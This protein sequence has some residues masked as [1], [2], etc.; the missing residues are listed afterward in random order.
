MAIVYILAITVVSVVARKSGRT[1]EGFVRGVRTY[2]AAVIGL[3]LASEVIGTSSSV[4]TAQGGFDDGIS[5]A[6]NLVA[7][8]LGFIA[9]AVF[10]ASRFK[11]L[12][13]V[14]ISGALE[15]C[16]GP[17]VRRAASITTTVA[18][19]LVATACY[20]GGGAVLSSL[21]GV[22]S[23][24]AVVIVGILASG[25]VALGGMQSVIYTNLLNV[26][27]KILSVVLVAV[28]AYRSAGGFGGVRL[29]LPPT[30]LD[31][32]GVGWAQIGAWLIAGGG[33]M[34]AT[35]YVVQSMTAVE[36][37]RKARTASLYTSLILIPYG[38]LAALIGVFAAVAHPDVPSIQA[39]PSMI[40]DMNPILAGIAATGLLASVFGQLSALT[41]G[42]ATL[43]FKDFY[44]P[45]F[46]RDSDDAKSVRFIRIATVVCGL[47]PVVLALFAT[48]IL[49]VAFLGK[50]LRALLS[51]FVVLMF[52]RPGFGSR[53]AATWS[54]WIAAAATISWFLIG[55][56]F[57]IDNAYVAIV[58]PLVIM[59]GAHVLR[60][61]TKPRPVLVPEAGAEPVAERST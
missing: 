51:V 11:K 44:L 8:G 17:G 5:A 32:D 54:V 35:Q 34:F 19:M 60:L 41:I 23:T 1:S 59:G 45:Y 22:S 25:Y 58:V 21:L 48:D 13:E 33:A 16:Y 10:L 50:A 9:F 24:W 2:P 26:V 28:A 53:E 30:M 61:G 52:Y 40:V 20:A 4:G 55:E 12:D 6:W 38:L 43:V 27:L 37:A 39:L 18:L 42:S 14:T 47:L 49:T 29:A 3:F 46:N 15:H 36:S 31:W 57:G 7:L 56:P